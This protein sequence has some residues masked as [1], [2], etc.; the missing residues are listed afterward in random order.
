MGRSVDMINQNIDIDIP[1]TLTMVEDLR[2]HEMKT[3]EDT[4]TRND[5]MEAYDARGYIKAGNYNKLKALWLRECYR[6]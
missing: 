2:E 1:S 4:Y 6:K 3:L 5:L